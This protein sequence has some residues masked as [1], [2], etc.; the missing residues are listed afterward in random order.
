MKPIILAPLIMLVWW[1]LYASYTTLRRKS[2]A[3]LALWMSAAFLVVV[4]CASI[5]N[6]DP[7]VPYRYPQATGLFP[8]VVSCAQ[9]SK[10]KGSGPN[11]KPTLIVQVEP[12]RDP[13][14]I[15]DYRVFGCTLYYY[16]RH[17]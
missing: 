3:E 16:H 4:V 11:W 14:R 6:S 15:R 5:A 10:P 9:E 1:F 13:G 7:Q 17:F 12:N 8:Q 2:V